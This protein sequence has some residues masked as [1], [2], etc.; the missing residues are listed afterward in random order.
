MYYEK[1]KEFVKLYSEDVIIDLKPM[2]IELI[3]EQKYEYVSFGEAMFRGSNGHLKEINKLI[4]VKDGVLKLQC[5]RYT[6]QELTDIFFNHVS[7]TEF[8]RFCEI[9]NID[10][11]FIYNWYLSFEQSYSP[12]HWMYRKDYKCFEKLLENKYKIYFRDEKRR[13]RNI[14]KKNRKLNKQNI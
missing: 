14:E 7:K 6:K 1:N 4:W 5:N 8:N 11:D 9:L 10:F 13:L 2:M 12:L 3:N